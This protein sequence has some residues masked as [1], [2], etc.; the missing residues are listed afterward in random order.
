MITLSS[1]TI[2]IGTI[3]TEQI[4]DNITASAQE[5]PDLTKHHHDTKMTVC[6]ASA[7]SLQ[8]FIRNVVRHH[9]GWNFYMVHGLIHIPNMTFGTYRWNEHEVQLTIERPLDNAVYFSA[10]GTV[11]NDM[12]KIVTMMCKHIST[13]TE[14]TLRML[15][16]P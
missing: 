6:A 5:I 1:L 14:E 3:G 9:R 13:S 10:I 11:H 12:E 4:N 2:G 8:P 7:E 16:H 15:Q